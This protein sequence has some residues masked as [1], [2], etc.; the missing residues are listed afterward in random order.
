MPKKIKIVGNALIV[1]DTITSVVEIDEPSKD[2]YFDN[3]KLNDGY[4]QITQ[5][6]GARSI[7]SSIGSKI[8]LGD[9]VDSND[10][11]FTASTFRLFMNLNTGSI[12]GDLAISNLP[13][14]A[15]NDLR[16]IEL[17]PQLQQSF[18][19]TVDNTDLTVNTVVNGGTI[20][21]TSG[22]GVLA[23]STTTL[24]SAKLLSKQHAKYRTG[25]GGLARFT[26]LFTSGV[27]NTEQYIG[28]MD[29]EGSSESFKN[30]YAIGFNGDT[31]SILRWQNDVLFNIEQADFDDPL[32][33]SGISGI[34]L[35][36]T[37]LSVFEINYQYLGAGAIYFSIE[38]P[39]TGYFV[40]FHII[41]Y[42]NSNIVPSTFNPNYKF[43]VWVDN[44][45]TESNL[46]LKTSSFAY[47][48]EGSTSFI[49]LHQPQNSTGIKSKNSVTTAVA[50]FTIRNKTSFASKTNFIDIFLEN[51]S[52]SIE[53]SAANN[54]GSVRLVKNATLGGTPSYSDIN[55]SNSVVEVDVAGTTVTGG[56]TIF[57]APLAGKNDKILEDL[58]EYKILLNPGETMTLEGLSA[59]SATMQGSLLWKELF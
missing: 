52:A 8:A 32:D 12:G 7:D 34:T 39:E 16:T 58:T 35:N 23:T 5:K 46:V 4:I 44:K 55:T 37:K 31:F 45:S 33:G 25:L 49:E 48:M 17:S 53:A 14:S 3:T 26:A 42:A 21:Q 2:V 24:S 57:P 19:Y 40:V 11:E 59:N 43:T 9:S 38:R 22:M 29:E 13:L 41:K 51:V 27:A 54:L 50:I 47:F 30:G 56:V 20:T 1:E 10:V 15:F 36:P 6:D 28:L 18:E